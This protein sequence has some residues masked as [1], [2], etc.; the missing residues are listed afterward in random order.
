MS[1]QKC[2]RTEC[3]LVDV[4]KYIYNPPEVQSFYEKQYWCVN[5]LV[6]EAIASKFKG[7]KPVDDKEDGV[8]LAI[9]G[10]IIK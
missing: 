3:H 6:A 5:C 7:K 2:G 4:R 10:N 8:Y 1:C 9:G